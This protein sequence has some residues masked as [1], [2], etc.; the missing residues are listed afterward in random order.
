MTL[1]GK[2]AIFDLDGTL[3]H[4]A[5]DLVRTLNCITQPF[6]LPPTDIGQIGTM[7]G[8]GAKAMIS[9]AFKIHQRALDNETLEQ[10]FAEFLEEYAANI[11]VESHLFEGAAAALDQLRN[12]GFS[13]AVCTNKTEHLAVKLLRELDVL[14][15]FSAVTGGNSFSFRKPDPNHLIQTAERA[16]QSGSWMVMIG[17]SINDIDAANAAGMESVA[18]TFGYSDVEA[19]RLGASA[20]IEHFDELLP[21]VRRLA[22]KH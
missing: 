12:D 18:V 22:K 21:A 13:L 14:N 3:A 11:A 6:D 15:Q 2:L 9:M 1:S 8:H 17:D 10:L 19:H 16:E 7:V 20:V 5:P 4:T